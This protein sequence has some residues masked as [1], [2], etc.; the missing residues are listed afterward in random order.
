MRM[1][2][3]RPRPGRLLPQDDPRVAIVDKQIQGL[4]RAAYMGFSHDW[5]DSAE[6]VNAVLAMDDAL[7]NRSTEWSRMPDM[8]PDP[9]TER[10]TT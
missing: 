3:S 9:L 4:I 2:T 7:H 8:L 5:R 10:P 1:T 6:I